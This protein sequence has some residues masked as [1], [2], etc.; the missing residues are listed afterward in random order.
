MSFN[1]IF[2]QFGDHQGIKVW[3]F[4]NCWSMKKKLQKRCW[5]WDKR[6]YQFQSIV[7][8]ILV[9]NDSYQKFQ[10]V[11]WLVLWQFIASHSSLFNLLIKTCY[12]LLVIRSVNERNVI[13][14]S[15]TDP[16]NVCIVQLPFDYSLFY[17]TDLPI[18][19]QRTFR[20][21]QFP[22]NRANFP[23]NT[24]SWL[25]I[26]H[27]KGDF[28]LICIDSTRGEDICACLEFIVDDLGRPASPTFGFGVR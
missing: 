22:Y 10:I 3:Y 4:Q 28:F 11:L 25:L 21:H 23:R 13:R 5:K 7:W 9:S 27:Q 8:H 1:L 19:F 24:N 16:V 14:V 18:A 12:S 26:F 2:S 20:G 6:G 15:T 17:T